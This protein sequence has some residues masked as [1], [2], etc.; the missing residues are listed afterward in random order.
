M[1]DTNPESTT[2]T[3]ETTPPTEP[4]NRNLRPGDEGYDIEWDPNAPCMYGSSDAKPNVL[5]TGCSDGGIGSALAR[6]FWDRGCHVYATA[7]DLGKMQAVSSID[8]VCML[9]LD[10]TKP[11]SIKAAAAV[12]ERQAGDRGLDIL[13]NNAARNRF[14][15]VL[16]E[17]LDAVRDTF[18]VNYVGPL[19]VTQAF[20]P[21]LI[22]AKGTSVYITSIAGYVTTPYMGSNCLGVYSG[23]KR[24]LEM[25]AETLRLELRPFG[26]DVMEIV[27]GAVRSNGQTY[28]G[29]WALPDG[30]LYKD[31]EPVVKH[32]AQGGDGLPRRDTAEYAAAVVDKILS[33]RTGAG[34]GTGSWLT[35]S[36][37]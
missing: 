24:A 11:E 7:R 32:R 30:S 36:G 8:N 1:G 25:L 15:P 3:T 9:A 29:D 6:A 5:I 28:F 21:L 26:V 23:L 35:W 16:D 22:K 27:T 31:I 17:D 19:A 13:V 37:A 33:K 34:S 4:Y 12:V 14:M 18:E 20:A 2:S 10:V